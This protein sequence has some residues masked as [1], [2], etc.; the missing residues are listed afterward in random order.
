MQFEARPPAGGEAC[1][2]AVLIYCAGANERSNEKMRRLRKSYKYTL[3]GM[4]KRMKKNTPQKVAIFD[5]DGT[6]FRSSLLIEIVEELIL[7]GI[8]PKKARDEY[9][10]AFKRWQSR[11]DEYDPY[12]NAVVQTFHRHI[13]GVEYARFVEAGECVVDKHKD[14]VYRY[15]RDL[16]SDLK[17]KGY[18]LLAISQ[19]PKDMLDKFCHNLGFDKVYGRIYEIGPGNKL[20]GNVSDLHLIANKANVVKRAIE[21]ENLT[22]Q[23]S[24]G[25]GDSEGDYAFL[26]L[27]ET[28]ICFNPSMILYR[29]AKRNRWKIIVE[30]KNVIYEIS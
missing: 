20:T 2:Q 22:L 5:I 8:F 4:I 21:K 30:R 28:P 10:P 11:K 13:K 6:I 17:K 9:L 26:E 18:Y 24:I 19:S 25:V 15:T 3:S 1:D 29:H 16:I 23:K 14:R 12:I 27:V 7:E